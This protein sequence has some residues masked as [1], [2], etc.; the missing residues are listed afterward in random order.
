MK[1]A[2]TSPIRYHLLKLSVISFGV[3]FSVMV[4]RIWLI[5]YISFG[6]DAALGFRV[7]IIMYIFCVAVVFEF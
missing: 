4:F 1:T 6:V 7:K 2:G 5:I 3:W